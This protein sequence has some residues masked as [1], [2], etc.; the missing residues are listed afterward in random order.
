MFTFVLVFL[1]NGKLDVS[2]NSVWIEQN[3]FFQHLERNRHNPSICWFRA[4]NCKKATRNFDFFSQAI[5]SG[6][7][8]F[9]EY[10]NLNYH[11]FWLFVYHKSIKNGP[12]SFRSLQKIIYFQYWGF[13]SVWKCKKILILY[14]FWILHPLLK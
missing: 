4:W 1:L 14:P 2:K 6:L 10:E 12:K 9:L 3:S 5:F 11:K 13:S 8:T 7:Y